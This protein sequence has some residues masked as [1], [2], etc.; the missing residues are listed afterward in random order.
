MATYRP[1]DWQPDEKTLKKWRDAVADGLSSKEFK[2]R[3]KISKGEANDK[4]RQAGQPLPDCEIGIVDARAAM[5]PSRLP[6]P[7]STLLSI[8]R[9]QGL[10][11]EEVRKNT[12]AG[13]R[14]CSGSK[15]SHWGKIRPGHAICDDCVTTRRQKTKPPRS[16]S[17][18]EES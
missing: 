12:E 1:K 18:H 11:Y 6:K 2:D 7:K 13:L 4:A 17:P 9:R 15:P 5:A 3:F 8:A 16:N 14:L 10:S